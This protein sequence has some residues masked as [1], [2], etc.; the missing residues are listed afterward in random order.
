LLAV[1]GVAG[2]TAAALGL[3]LRGWIVEVTMPCG[4]SSP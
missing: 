4:V 1:F 2:G 3:G